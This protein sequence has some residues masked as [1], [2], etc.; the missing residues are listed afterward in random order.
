MNL[1]IMNF[2]FIFLASLFSPKAFCDIYYGVLHGNKVIHFKSPYP[3]IVKLSDIEEGEIKQ[4][5]TLFK[6]LNHEYNSKNLLIEKKL[7]AER[8]KKHRLQT[9]YKESK[10][11]YESG[12]ISKDELLDIEDKINDSN[13]TIINLNVEQ[14]NIANMLKLAKPFVNSTFI[15]RNIFVNNEQYVNSG[16][17]IIDIEL[18]DKFFID[19]KIDPVSLHGNIKEKKIEYRSLVN[20]LSGFASVIRVTRTTESGQDDKSSGL[21]V[22]TLN[23][24]GDH[25]KLSELLDTAFEIEIK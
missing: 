18:L 5:I 7:Q 6:V 15:I 12:Y 20:G 9:D 16:D 2:I 8:K 24:T 13:M 22:I 23:I 21:R 3:G 1:C 17:D 19:V 11:A 4:N 25:K 14:D 10:Y